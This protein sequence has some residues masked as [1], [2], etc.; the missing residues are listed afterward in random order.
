ME[1]GQKVTITNTNSV[2]DGMQ[3]T[4]EECG[5]GKCTVMVDFDSEKG[6]KV[7]QDFEESCLSPLQESK[8][9]R[10]LPE[11]LG[12]QSRR[13]LLASFLGIEPDELKDGYDENVFEGDGG[14]WMVLTY[15]EAEQEADRQI[16]E[17]F[18]ED[19]LYSFTE[20]FQDWIVNNAINQNQ[21]HDLMDDYYESY[22]EDIEDEDDTEFGNRLIQEMFSA[23][24]LKDE[25]FEV[26]DDGEID[27]SMVKDSVDLDTKENE[28]V[29]RLAGQES[30][31]EWL[32]GFY[33]DSELAEFL[34]D[35]GLIDLD[36]VVEECISLDGVGHFIATYD[37]DE[38]DLGQGLYGYR[39]NGL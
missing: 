18:D 12:K 38:A 22:A 5:E 1:K 37:G 24:I 36:A 27:H 17:I 25:D 10:A 11:A 28:F 20:D 32:K 8:H 19:G 15:E 2:W 34:T 35:N 30:P 9:K 29:E 16:R 39:L 3:G 21:I 4:I 6:K 26:G 14:E 7:R 31:I 33:N 13:E 23:G